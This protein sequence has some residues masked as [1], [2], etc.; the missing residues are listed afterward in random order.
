MGVIMRIVQL[1]LFVV[2]TMTLLALAEAGAAPH[3]SLQPR[4]RV[5][6]KRHYGPLQPIGAFVH[7]TFNACRARGASD[8][9]NP[10][11]VRLWTL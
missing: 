10:E 7:P 4:I 11:T 5:R 3:A 2:W 1:L 6:S 8:P 9:F